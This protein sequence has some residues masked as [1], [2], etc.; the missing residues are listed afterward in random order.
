MALMEWT[1]ALSVKIGIIDEQHKRLFGYVNELYDA[2]EQG[3]AQDVLIRIFD[4][5]DEYTKTH[6]SLE[7]SYFEKFGYAE[8][9]PHVAQHQIFIRKLGDFRK[10]ILAGNEDVEDLLDFLVDWLMHHIKGTD[11]MYV[12]CFH[13]HGL[14]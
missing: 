2:L 9:G 3:K 14:V 7:E 10:Q 12:Q 6:F 5:L 1:T 11:H 4:S 8:K 13:E